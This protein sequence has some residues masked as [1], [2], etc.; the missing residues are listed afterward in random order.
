MGNSQ[1]RYTDEDHAIIERCLD[2]GWSFLEISRTYGYSQ[3]HLSDKYRGR[4]WSFSQA[5]EHGMFVRLL[6]RTTS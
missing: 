3:G 6:G 4:G 2:E 5:A 1:R